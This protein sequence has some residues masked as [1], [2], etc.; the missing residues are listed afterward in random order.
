[1]GLLIDIR[2]PVDKEVSRFED[3]FKQQFKSPVFLLDQIINRIIR[4][5]GKQLRPLIIFLT[6]KLSGSVN[7]KTYDAATLIELLHIATLVHDDIVDE[8]FERRN[9]Y[10]VNALWKSKKA[11][12]I[13]DYLLARGMVLALEKKNYDLLHV[14]SSAVSEMSEG[15]LLQ[16][17]VSRKNQIA[18]DSYFE[19]IR[20]KTA[21]FFSASTGCGT[22]SVSGNIDLV[23]KMK[24]FGETIGMIFQITDDLF[25]YQSKN[26]TGKPSGNDIKNMKFTLPLL[27]AMESA[28]ISK[29]STFLSMVK[30]E[31]SKSFDQ[32]VNDFIINNKGF[33][34]THQ[35]INYY[36]AIALSMLTSFPESE[37][38]TSLIKLIDF[39][40][41]RKD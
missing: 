26:E 37:A 17:S 34:K 16:D 24:I 19:V 4:S 7:E 36:K 30:K 1:M 22:I 31:P 40:I 6:A 12:L 35:K 9:K 15:E 18:I 38:K 5:K 39:I 25:D 3:Y 13:G 14:I 11:V 41:E 29:K 2:K 21:V 33:E 20:K 8:A 23:N 32:I 28:G 10:S 27:Y